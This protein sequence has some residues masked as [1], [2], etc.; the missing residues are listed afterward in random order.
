MS[1]SERRV[2]G[3]LLANLFGDLLLCAHRVNRHYAALDM[4]Q[5]QQFWDGRNFIRLLVN[6][7][8]S[9]RQPIAPGPGADQVDRPLAF[10]PVMRAT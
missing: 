5:A 10:T 1:L 4:E 8:L 3:A 6:F 9:E 7:D 2:I